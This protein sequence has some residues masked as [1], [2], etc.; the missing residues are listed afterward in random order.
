MIT[1]FKL[2]NL[3]YVYSHGY[4]YS[5]QMLGTIF[6]A[7]QTCTLFGIVTRGNNDLFKVGCVRSAYGRGPWLITSVCGGS[8]HRVSSSR[9]EQG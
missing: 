8:R 9:S 7:E 3:R 1:S 2:R 6:G 5:P 4:A